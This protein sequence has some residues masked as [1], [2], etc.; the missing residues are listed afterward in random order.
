MAQEKVIRNNLQIVV[1][2]NLNDVTM[3]TGAVFG[4]IVIDTIKKTF[5]VG[6]NKIVAKNINNV[7]HDVLLSLKE[8]KKASANTNV[9]T[10]SSADEILKY[11]DLLDM[12]AITQDEFDEKKRQLLG[13]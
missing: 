8:D 10:A 9:L 13:L 5:N 11:K 4:I 1:I 12:G 2:D 3:T 7:I 6:V